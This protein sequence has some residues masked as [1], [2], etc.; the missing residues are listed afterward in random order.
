MF[1]PE[2]L[3]SSDVD[4]RTFPS[5]QLL[6]GSWT[7]F[8]PH[9]SKLSIWRRRGRKQCLPAD[10]VGPIEVLRSPLGQTMT[11]FD[12]EPFLVVGRLWESSTSS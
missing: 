11:P 2:F 8:S 6:Q 3:T 10:C 1:G 5:S 4:P 7:G 9:P 12:A